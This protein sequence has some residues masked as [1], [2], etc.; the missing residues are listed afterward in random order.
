MV[1]EFEIAPEARP[2]L[3]TL[4]DAREL[5]LPHR[6]ATDVWDR[7]FRSRL[8]SLLHPDGEV[9]DIGAGRRPT[10]GPEDRPDGTRYVGLDLDADELKKAPPGSYDDTVVAPAEERV[11]SLED[12]F[13]LVL[14]FFALEHVSST[15]R[16]LENARAYLRPGGW[17]LAQTAGSRSPFAIGN[18]ILPPRIA[19]LV[20]QRT[21][22]RDADAIFPARYDQCRYSALT[23]LLDDW[24][25]HEVV[26]L[27][28]GAGYA[29]FSR[30]LT[31]AYVASEEWIYRTGRRDLAPYYLVAARR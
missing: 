5:R 13:D 14:S 12:R 22:S 31:V 11:P 3:A 4:R 30:A 26:P 29:L 15:A 27:F 7:P 23:A 18:R 25:E 2:P 21:Q 6:Y 1:R 24:S 17:L 9:L 10:V 20:L 8:A 19:Q 16:V 28:T